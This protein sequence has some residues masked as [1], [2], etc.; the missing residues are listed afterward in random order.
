M[1]G[2][3]R[4]PVTRGR[5]CLLGVERTRFHFAGLRSR[6]KPMMSGLAHH[7]LKLAI[8]RLAFSPSGVMGWQFGLAILLK[9]KKQG[10]HLT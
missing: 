4:R 5:Y 6:N 2:R 7:R 1:A 10:D 9:A 8:A 3:F